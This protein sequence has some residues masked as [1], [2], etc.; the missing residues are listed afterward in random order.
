MDSEDRTVLGREALAYADALYNLAR[1]LT[2]NG[3]DAE[4]LVQETYMRAL[5]AS[6]RFTLGT[7]L[8]AW[9]FRI[10]RNTFISQYRRDRHNP[11]IGGLD[12]VE[13]D[14]AV[15]ETWLRDDIELDRL[16][17]VVAEDIERAFMRLS[18]DARTVVVLDLEGLTEAE[19]AEVIGCPVGTVKS[20][21]ARAR[22]ALRQAL[23][24]YAR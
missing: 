24:D 19:V 2:G 1:Y 4:D 10:L 12:T 17:K 14:I 22:A 11:M 16:R 18:D 13:R 9:L 20:R 7:N 6:D 23:R 8:K 15:E 5:G 3:A 21:L